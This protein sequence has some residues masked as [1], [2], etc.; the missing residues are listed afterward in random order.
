VLRL[1]H[2]KH[3]L[4]HDLRYRRHSLHT[5]FGEPVGSRG[6]F[7]TESREHFGDVVVARDHPCV[8]ESVPQ[9]RGLLTQSRVQRVWVGEDVW[10]E[11]MEEA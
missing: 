9:H 3:L 1:I 5:E 7:R 11:Q 10:I 8:Q 6:P 2:E 4:D